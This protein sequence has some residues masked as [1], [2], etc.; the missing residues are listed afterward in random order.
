MKSVIWMMWRV[1][2]TIVSLKMEEAT[3]KGMW[4]PLEVQHGLQSI[5]F[6]S[7][8]QL[9]L[10]LCDTSLP[11]PLPTPRAC[12][13]SCPSSQWCPPTIPSSVVPFSC[14]QSFPASV[15][16]PM[17]QFF[18]SGGQSVR[19][20]ASASVLPM[21]IQIFSQQPARKQGPQFCGCGNWI[22]L[23]IGIR[24]EMTSRWELEP[25]DNN[26]SWWTPWFLPQWA[27]KFPW[28]C[29]SSCCRFPKSQSFKI[30]WHL[31]FGIN[32]YALLYIKQITSKDLPYGTRN[33]IQQSEIVY[34]GKESEKE[35]VYIYICTN[36][37]TH[38]HTHKYKTELLCCIP[39]TNITLQ[40]NYT[41]MKNFNLIKKFYD[42]W[43]KAN[44]T[45]FCIIFLSLYPW[46]ISIFL[47]YFKI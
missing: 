43:V 17:S 26:S 7:V 24:L 33:Y 16:F 11:C 42:T 25:P 19:V 34:M 18:T 9:C 12:S 8:A 1:W 30:L 15:S 40:I 6:T 20:S 29:T 4:W 31:N 10:T 46:W 44:S 5:Q 28:Y 22:W 13:N 36:M 23:S 2:Y 39:E 37:H 21:N 27:W 35:Y 3:W 38:T 45:N 41:S 14:L 47:C 32:I